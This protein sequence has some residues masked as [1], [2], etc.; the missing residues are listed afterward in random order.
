VI[1]PT[2]D[3]RRSAHRPPTKPLKG[4]DAWVHGLIGTYRR[5]PQ[6]LSGL[7]REAET[8]DAQAD[9]WTHLNDHHLQERL[10]DLSRTLRRT[11]KP[12]PETLH[13]A[14]AAL[15]E[16]ADRRL[17]L[18]PFTVQLAGVLA[19]HRGYLAEMATGEGK[20]L[21]AGIAAV[22]AGWTGRPCHIITANDYLVQRDTEW[23]RPLHSFCGLRGGCVTGDMAV[24]D[25]RHGYDADITYTTSKEIVADFLRDRLR[26]GVWQEPARRLIRTLVN[27][28]LLVR[29]DLVM[30]GLHTAVVDEAD[31]LLIDEAVTP[32]IISAPSKNEMLREACRLAQGVA[33]DLER[34]TDY[35]LNLRYREV[36]LN[37]DG[38]ARISARAETLPALFR[39]V[40]RQEELV[41]QALVAR[42][43]FHNG[44]QYV[45]VDGKVVIVDEFT[46]RIMPQRTWRAGLHQAIEAKEGLDIT[47]P[48]ETLARLSFQRFFRLFTRLAGMTGTAREASAEFWQTYKLPVVAIPTHKPCIRKLMPDR[49]FAHSDARWEAVVEEIER[50]HRTGRPVLVGTR[51]VTAS[52]HLGSRLQERGLECLVLNAVRHR[53]EAQIVAQAGLRGRITIATNM[54]GRGTDIRLGHGLAE[55]GGLHVIATERHESHRIDRQLFGRAARQ[56]DPGSAQPFVSLEDELL[57]RYL[58]ATV[59]QRLMESIRSSPGGR[60]PVIHSLI[61]L[62]QR[63]SERQAFRQ[64]KAVLRMDTWLEDALSFTGPSASV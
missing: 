36:D 55:E 20:T 22:L 58:P 54:A 63:R 23:L 44:K 14:L 12:A 48:T 59:R 16:A 31:S 9:S 46:G 28:Q 13:Q 39:S 19:L 5:R 61:S 4:M 17:G 51:N 60:H 7:L 34:E 43:F 26:L 27:P 41:R 52:E 21:V 62:A 32:L 3:F 40:S 18:R 35:E 1:I 37:D 24:P 45:V 47:D 30:R 8:I 33:A 10:A 25:R 53:E 38:R 49:I 57:V 29:S 64:R 15:R 11:A 50:V 6:I 2:Q 56:G 42:E